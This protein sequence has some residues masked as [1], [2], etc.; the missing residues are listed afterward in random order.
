MR[1]K[2]WGRC[3]GPLRKAPQSTVSSLRRQLLRPLVVPLVFACA[4][5]A[6]A[7]PLRQRPSQADQSGPGASARPVEQAAQLSR[8]VRQPNRVIADSIAGHEAEPRSGTREEWLAAA[9]H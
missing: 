7:A 9:K 8:N 5:A 3:D 6:L 1:P 4:D 2:W